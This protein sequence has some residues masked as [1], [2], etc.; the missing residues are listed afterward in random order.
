MLA[1]YYGCQSKREK[2]KS[3]D[4]SREILYRWGTPVQSEDALSRSQ[5]LPRA[6]VGKRSL[7]MCRLWEGDYGK[8]EGCERLP[9][10]ALKR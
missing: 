7:Y 5:I 1:K 6:G 2:K 9:G 8:R 3:L 10:K 4:I